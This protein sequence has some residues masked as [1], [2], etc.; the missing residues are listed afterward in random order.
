MTAAVE[1][2]TVLF[3]DLVGSTEMASG[4]A[5]DA[6]DR[7]RREHFACLRRQVASS[8]GVEVKNLGDGLMIVF[9][10]ASAG[11]ACAVAMQQAVDRDN[12]LG[13]PSLGLRIGIASGE[14]TREGDD[15]FGDPVIEAARLCAH[16]SG[17]QIVAS[18][19]VRATAGR[20]S[21]HSFAPLGELQLKGLPEPTLACEVV[22]EPAG[23]DGDGGDVVPL[24]SRL[25]RQP[26]IGLIGRSD[27][28][29]ILADAFK[30][31]GGGAGREVVLVSAEAGMGKT[32]LAAAAAGTAHAARACV[33]LGRCEE[34]LG[35]PYGP[36]VEALGHYVAHAPQE[37][38]EA[39]ARSHGAHLGRLLPGLHDRLGQVPAVPDGDP[40]AERYL[41]FGAVTALLGAACARQ[42]VVLVLDDLQWADRPSLQ[43][44]RYVA[45]HTEAMRLLIIGTYRDAGLSASHPLTEALAALHRE[46]AVNRIQLRGLDDSAVLSFLQAAAGHDLDEAGVG[47]AH[48][49]YR[50]TDGN[51]F[52]VGEVLRH[53][54]ETGAIYQDVEGRWRA[55]A[56]LGSVSLPDSVRHV[57]GAR[58][59]GLGGPALEVLSLAAV[60]GRDFDLGV[61]G[62]VSGQPED[63]L[64][65]VLEAA[66]SRALVREVADRP[67]RY[68]FSHALVRHTLYQDLGATRRARAHRAVAEALEE[69]CGDDPGDR[70]G[71][72]AHHWASA[73]QAVDAARAIGY[74]RQAAEAALA[75]LAPEDAARHYAQAL[76]LAEH[77]RHADPLQNVDLRI[78]LGTAQRQAGIP[79]FRETLLAA[80]DAARRLGATDRLVSAVLA[81]NRGT[82]SAL[83]LVDRER[84]AAVEAALSSVSDDDTA[85]RALLLATLAVELTWDPL[86]RALPLAEEAKAVARRLDEPT[87][88]VQVMNL[89]RQA[90]DVPSTL[91]QRV[92]DAEESYC[93]ATQ[94]GDPVALFW[95]G[96]HRLMVAEQSGDFEVAAGCLATLR[97]EAERLKQPAMLYWARLCEAADALVRGDHE[98]AEIMATE[99]FRIADE[100]SHPDAFAYYGA[101]LLLVRMQQ[102]R[103]GELV[104]MLSQ[105]VAANPNVPA[106]RGALAE[107]LLEAGQPEEARRLLEA[108]AAT[109]FS[110]LPLDPAW[111]IG[112]ALYADVAIE[113]RHAP[114]AAKLVKH[115]A[116]YHDQIPFNSLIRHEPVAFSLGALAT[117]LGRYDEAEEYL[118]NALEICRRGEMKFSE[119]RTQLAIARMLLQ[120]RQ[121][122]DLEQARHT[123]ECALVTAVSRGYA[124]LEAKVRALAATAA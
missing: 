9:T 99:A 106:Y 34:D 85:E 28:I 53:L 24:P 114:G 122:D 98:G 19:L 62:R 108:A 31:A 69:I 16:A 110:C 44:L 43:L 14:A 65:G 119:V 20:R 82:Y 29:T 57:I 101:Q 13:E 10:T 95:A 4:L 39:H 77:H 64:L 42:P 80:A 18:D 112:M 121:E 115:L 2:I 5:P 26:T 3:T 90:R 40:D 97:A 35:A 60:I 88:L 21:P 116:P 59:A 111:S 96:V 71:E 81:N 52:F 51:P 87:V 41:V 113:L 120:R 89:T 66:A 67:G 63:E 12:R 75:A 74:S 76:Q 73:L 91:G 83:G 79:A 58:A 100:I 46:S 109:D 55:P 94:L 104:S 118:S 32:T 37:L 103:L 72:L 15:Y 50:E 70:I 45:A 124:S 105:V 22:W 17:G 49:V 8:G 25:A 38:L 84:V 123:L 33:L 93:L 61:L 1:N 47:L 27:E 36:F 92:Q 78:G 11:L 7:L 102:G 54:A 48:A 56:D 6:A 117:V 68:S 86:G 107:A 23:A 30:R